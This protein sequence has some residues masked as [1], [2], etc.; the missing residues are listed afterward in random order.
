MIMIYQPEVN[1]MKPCNWS[2]LFF[3]TASHPSQWDLIFVAGSVS[4]Q[5]SQL[6]V[7]CISL[8]DLHSQKSTG[9]WGIRCHV[10]M[11]GCRCSKNI[12]SQ[13]L[14][15]CYISNAHLPQLFVWLTFL[16][17]V[18]TFE[19]DVPFCIRWKSNN[20]I[21]VIPIPRPQCFPKN[22]RMGESRRFSTCSC[23]AKEAAW[24]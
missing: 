24:P 6:Y 23:C 21:L 12:I 17:R 11:P 10:I 1:I 15:H 18:R 19:D 16:L 22:N 9:F 14:A 7:R 5:H 13:W 8:A 3:L 4:W 20:F 2:I